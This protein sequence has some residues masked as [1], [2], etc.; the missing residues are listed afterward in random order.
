MSDLSILPSNA[1]AINGTRPVTTSLVV[2]DVFGKRHDNVLRD[3]ETLEC[4]DA[5]RLL[6]FEE[7]NRE[8]VTGKNTVQEYRYFDITKDGFVFLVMG[9][10]GAKAAQFKEAYIS[11]FNELEDGLRSPTLPA[12]PALI[13]VA[14]QGELAT[15]IAERFPNG[16]NRPYAWSR[17]NNHFRLSR[18]R[19]LPA[20]RFEEAC[21]YIP[22]MALPGGA[23]TPALPAPAD[24]LTPA[25]L[26]AIDRRAHAV[27]LRD[28]DRLRADLRQAV[29]H[30]LTHCPTDS[31]AELVRWVEQVERPTSGSVSV[32]S[33]E[34]WQVCSVVASMA[35]LHQHVMERLHVLEQ[36]T[37]REWYG[38]SA[39]D[40][41]I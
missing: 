20:A 17:F 41:Q 24:P 3:I 13:T 21:A 5:F 35:L 6:N 38:R 16:K 34:L 37:G 27:S 4:S 18:Y 31:E 23:E 12:I 40:R 8:L 7:R 36:V 1:V 33:D 30:H 26:T 25:V 9:Y 22:A 29:R 19:D 39:R 28:F 32:P 15:L 10:R 2:A 11:R 14:Q